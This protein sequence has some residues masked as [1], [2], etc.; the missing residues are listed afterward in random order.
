MEESLA[1]LFFENMPCRLRPDDLPTTGAAYPSG[2]E[3][4]LIAEDMPEVRQLARSTLAQRGYQ[5]LEAANG[6]AALALAARHPGTIHLVE[7][8]R[9]HGEA[10][11]SDETMAQLRR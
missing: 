7:W 10:Q 8:L 9:V 11:L 6:S 4:I 2:T 5:V 3:T 1:S